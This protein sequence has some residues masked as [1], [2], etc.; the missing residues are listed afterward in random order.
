MRL[1]LPFLFSLFALGCSIETTSTNTPGGSTPSETPENG[2]P[3]DST[4]PTTPDEPKEPWA[5][6][7]A[8]AEVRQMT[9]PT[10]DSVHIATSKGLYTFANDA[11]KLVAEGDF[12]SVHLHDA[13]LGYAAGDSLLWQRL[14]GEWAALDGA[15]AYKINNVYTSAEGVYLV[16]SG[17]MYTG[18]NGFPVEPKVMF[19]ANDLTMRPERAYGNR[20]TAGSIVSIAGAGSTVAL[21]GSLT[22]V[23]SSS[24]S[25]WQPF[26]DD[27]YLTGTLRSVA[28]TSM[29]LYAT[30]GSEIAMPHGV[31]Y[32]PVGGGPDI[33]HL[34]TWTNYVVAVGAKGAILVLGPKDDDQMFSAP[35]SD[36][37]SAGCATKDGNIWVAAGTKVLR[38]RD[39]I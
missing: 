39:P 16:G 38:R 32:D 21:G 18:R 9:C 6:S 11:W 7:T 30:N 35:T 10:D 3:G 34:F 13:K 37:L 15:A 22:M 2:T 20:L 19:V 5:S 25:E 8:P 1:T 36:T 31:R 33:H 24:G 26:P 12:K 17:F 23:Y 29:G 28:V 27:Y 4:K 14:N